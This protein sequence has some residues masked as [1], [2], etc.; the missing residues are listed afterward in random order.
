MKHIAVYKSKN[1]ISRKFATFNSMD[2]LCQMLRVREADVVDCL[3]GETS[4]VVSRPGF[5][6]KRSAYTFR[7]IDASTKGQC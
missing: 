5:S 1:G 2:E 4:R 3:Y 6:G 7:E